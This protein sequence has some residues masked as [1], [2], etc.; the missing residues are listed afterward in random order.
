MSENFV[1]EWNH[2]ASQVYINACEKGF[3]Q[4]REYVIAT[5]TAGRL[6]VQAQ[7]LALIHSEISE[8]LEALRRG[9]DKEPDEHCSRFAVEVELADAVIRIMDLGV[10][11]GWDVAGA[12]LDKLAYNEGRERMHGGKRF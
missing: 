10:R 3:W 7:A 8:A 2:I 12:L 6:A 5:G 4:A 9:G 1:T 11:M